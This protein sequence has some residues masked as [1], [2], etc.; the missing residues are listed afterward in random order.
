VL[1]APGFKEHGRLVPQKFIGDIVSSH[2][3]LL[4][5]AGRLTVVQKPV[6]SRSKSR[7]RVSFNADSEEFQ[8]SCGGGECWVFEFDTPFCDRGTPVADD[9][10]DEIVCHGAGPRVST[11]SGSFKVIQL[12]ESEGG[13]WVLDEPGSKVDRQRV[14]VKFVH[15]IKQ[16][17]KKG[18]LSLVGG[19]FAVVERPPAVFKTSGPRLPMKRTRSETVLGHHEPSLRRVCSSP[20]MP[21]VH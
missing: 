18:S 3:F 2:A 1:D 8:I 6:T 13:A 19:D 11:P 12:P 15:G 17:A 9:F 21:T 7:R 16:H 4:L 10:V 14:P 20:A 5:K